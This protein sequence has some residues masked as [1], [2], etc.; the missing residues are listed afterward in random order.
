MS[1]LKA[2]SLLMTF[3]EVEVL[4][5]K[6]SQTLFATLRV[7]VAACVLVTGLGAPVDA[8][9]EISV[10]VDD[11]FVAEPH[12]GIIVSQ[13]MSLAGFLTLHKLV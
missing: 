1:L 8:A 3:Q 12:G 2:Y 6:N 9:T 11:S 13:N 4:F 10:V 7:A 5:T